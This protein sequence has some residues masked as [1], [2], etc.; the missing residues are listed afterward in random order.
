MKNAPRLVREVLDIPSR[1]QRVVNED[2]V[3]LL[4]E[5]QA[6]GSQGAG[7]TVKQ[8]LE[9]PQL[10]TGA[11]VYLK[12]SKFRPNS[13]RNIGD[14]TLL[15][16]DTDFIYIAHPCVSFGFVYTLSDMASKSNIGIFPILSVQLS[17]SGIDGYKQASHMHIRQSHAQLRMATKWYV[18]YVQMFDGIVSDFEH[19][20]GGK[21]HW[22]PLVQTAIEHGLRA[23]VVDAETGART[24]VNQNTPD[25]A[26]WSLNDAN[27]KV[28]L[29]LEKPQK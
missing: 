7:F 29:L 24:P 21:A 11:V 14:H 23:Y 25:A 13:L 2:M 22:K 17:D 27:R 8:W 3:A 15:G 5:H 6:E 4:R 12:D 20:E 28:M 16:M 18:R 10:H 9:K 1:A 19:L 26:I